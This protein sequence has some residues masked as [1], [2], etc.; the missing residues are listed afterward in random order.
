[1]FKTL[2]SLQMMWASALAS[3]GINEST[4]I[5]L[6]LFLAGIAGTAAILYRA[7]RDRQMLTDRLEQ[8][9]KRLTELANN[10]RANKCAIDQSPPPSKPECSG[11]DRGS[12]C[13]VSKS[14]D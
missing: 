4:D 10:C 3:A 6:S 9:D 5:S 11:P 1:M 12:V 7:G 8:L 2:A 14:E 13:K